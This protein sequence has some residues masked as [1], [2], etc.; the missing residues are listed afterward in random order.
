MHRAV[1]P[2]STMGEEQHNSKGAGG[3]VAH[4]T[5][6]LND[7]ESRMVDAWMATH[8]GCDTD[9]GEPLTDESRR[10]SR[11]EAVRGVMELVGLWPAADVPADLTQRT[12]RTITQEEQRRRFAHL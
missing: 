5:A 9:A 11:A 1:W 6:R 2:G 3:P 7:D 12:L 10:A 4:L 8:T